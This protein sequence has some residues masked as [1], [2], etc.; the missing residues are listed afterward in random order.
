[1]MYVLLKWLIYVICT[2]NGLYEC[3]F[4]SLDRVEILST[5]L[6]NDILKEQ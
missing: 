2:M 1:M 6:S 4:S 3:K 5:Q